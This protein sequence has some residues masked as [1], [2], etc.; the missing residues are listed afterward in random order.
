MVD[1][2]LLVLKIKNLSPSKFADEI[3]IQRSSMSHIMSGRNLPSLDLILK[4]LQQFKDINPEWLM[5][6][7]GPMLKTSQI[8][9]FETAEQIKE[10]KIIPEVK[11]ESNPILEGINEVKVLIEDKKETEKEVQIPLEPMEKVE[12]K[13][14]TD[15]KQQNKPAS[16][17]SE[18]EKIVVLYKNNTFKEYHPGL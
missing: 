17:S 18:I 8:D 5:Q 9:L 2:I 6:G 14:I 7:N 10:D 1:R 13:E 16:N 4:M 15:E 3:G 11:I 12:N